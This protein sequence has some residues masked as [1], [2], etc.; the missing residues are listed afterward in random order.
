MSLRQW[1]ENGWL[2]KEPTS[3]NEIENLLAIVER[4]L[5]DATKP[6]SPD[7]QFG[8]AYNAA[9]KLCMILLRS[10]G[11][12]PGH[13]LQHYRTIMAMP[14]VLGRSRRPDAE[15]LDSCR[16]KRN[17]AEYDYVGGIGEG[18]AVEL[19]GFVGKFEVEV[20]TWL[21]AHHPE[22]VP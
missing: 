21:K 5:A 4:D 20:I 7:W 16:I 18:E 15:Y 6:V 17:A 1:E 10:E 14:L 11:F 13:G 22:I 3:R 19:I 9:L 8:I 2:R 12:R